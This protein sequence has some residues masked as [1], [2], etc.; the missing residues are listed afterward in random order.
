MLSTRSA[1][2]VRIAA[3]RTR[4]YTRCQV[5]SFTLLWTRTLPR[6]RPDSPEKTHSFSHSTGVETVVQGIPTTPRATVRHIFGN[7]SGSATAYWKLSN[8][9]F[10]WSDRK[11]S[12]EAARSLENALSFLGFTN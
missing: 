9:S 7:K 5:R 11:Y 6:W 1:S 8:A 12:L 10:T 2:I 3:P 4:S